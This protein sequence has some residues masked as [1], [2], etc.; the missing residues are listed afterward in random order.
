MIAETILFA[1]SHPRSVKE[2][3]SHCDSDRR[4]I[5]CDNGVRQNG[6]HQIFLIV[7]GISTIR[8]PFLLGCKVQSYQ[9]VRASLVS[10]WD[11]FVCFWTEKASLPHQLYLYSNCHFYGVAKKE[12]TRAVRSLSVELGFFRPE[13]SIAAVFER[14]LK[15]FWIRG[16]GLMSGKWILPVSESSIWIPSRGIVI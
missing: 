3:T 15:Y 8:I 7:L 1:A 12:T 5:R 2:L 14:F 16:E 11:W 4:V 9:Q 13:F 10:I 6:C